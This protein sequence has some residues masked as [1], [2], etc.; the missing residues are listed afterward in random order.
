MKSRQHAVVEFVVNGSRLK[1]FFPK[2]SCMVWFALAGIRCPSIS[3]KEG[4]PSE[5]FGDE[6]ALFTR[7]SCLHHEVDIEI[8]A[9][10][11]GG[12]F[13]GTMWINK[14]SLAVTLLEEG[15]ATLHEFSASKSSHFVEL[16]DAEQKA[17]ASKKKIYQNWTEKK[18]EE[19]EEIPPANVEYI[20]LLVTEVLDGKRFYAQFIS[21]SI[22]DLENMMKDLNIT[23][24]DAE[25]RHQAS[26]GIGAYCCAQY[27]EDD[28]WYRALVREITSEGNY[29]VLYIDFGNNE[30]V[31]PSRIV[32]I[33]SKFLQLKPQAS[34]CALAYVKVPEPGIDDFGY[35]AARWLKEA[36]LGQKMT[37]TIERRVAD[38]YQ[39]VL[40]E[41]GNDRTSINAELVRAG[42]ARVEKRTEAHLQ[43]IMTS[44]DESQEQAKEAKIFLWC[45]GDTYNSDDEE[46]HRGSGSR[47]GRGRGGSRGNRGRG[48]N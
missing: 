20:E 47:G 6:A 39:V 24:S 15:L 19:D 26:P 31:P 3:R 42:L 23:L 4:E 44:L 35:D 2:E 41:S 28:A 27:G 48:K 12:T 46:E 7:R 22:G 21:D 33:D 25:N 32:A 36:L 18:D 9:Q 10:D 45:Y 11:K 1:L 40:Y 14:K 17:I 34:L 38:T 16:R 37:A 43:T 5:P 30:I 29:N 13:I 8:E